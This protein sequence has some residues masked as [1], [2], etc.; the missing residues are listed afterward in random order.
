MPTRKKSIQFSQLDEETDTADYDSEVDPV[1][2]SQTLTEELQQEKVIKSGYLLKKGERR[3]SWKKRWF[4]LRKTKLAYYKDEK[5]YKLLHIINMSI[6]HA[7]DE[8]KIKTHAYCFGI[9][10]RQRTYYMKA[11]SREELDE[12][13]EALWH[14]QTAISSSRQNSIVREDGVRSPADGKSG[15][16]GEN[17]AEPF[18]QSPE[19][20][21]SINDQIENLPEGD[22]VAN[23]NVSL[24]RKVSLTHPPPPSSVNEPVLRITTALTTDRPSSKP[25][26][27]GDPFQ[28]TTSPYSFSPT[29]HSP[30]FQMQQN[31]DIIDPGNEFIESSE[32]EGDFFED[33]E[34]E[35]PT[36]DEPAGRKE[37]NVVVTSGYLLKRGA[38][39]NGW[40]KR[41]FV[42]RNQ[43]LSYYKN[44]KEYEIRGMIPLR[45]VL[46]VLDCTPPTKHKRHCFR[47]ITPSRPF[48]CCAES[49]E[50]A[51]AWISALRGEL[52]EVKNTIS[53]VYDE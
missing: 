13:L 18:S 3:K 16:S 43:K 30:L 28:S 5:E 35:I 47:V 53:S 21:D 25:L 12:W 51:K 2:E 26:R 19:G 46:D 1:E 4:V 31:S 37:D 39:Y 33:E 11:A 8:V 20:D 40:K 42:L 32:E 45:S 6:A 23:G 15:E 50:S 52:A 36:T 34:G 14:V 17:V 41:W 22:A 9:V 27:P 38:K 10:T 29:A 24:L 44:E 49:A 48:I 7:I